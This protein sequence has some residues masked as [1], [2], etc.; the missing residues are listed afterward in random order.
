VHD[1]GIGMTPEQQSRLFKAFSQADSSTTRRFGGT[2]LGLS[3]SRSLALELGGD[4]TLESTPGQGSC[5]TLRTP[6]GSLDGVPLIS[7]QQAAGIVFS[8]ASPEDSNSRTPSKAPLEGVRIFFAEDGLDNQRLIMHH[9]RTAGA[10]VTVFNNGRL[11]LEALTE[12]GTV[13]GPLR[14]PRP[15]DVVVTD[16]QMP[17]MDGYT[18]ARTLRTKGWTRPIIALTA[19][20]MAS[21]AE[22]CLR[23][24]CD[25]YASKPVDRDELISMCQFKPGQTTPNKAA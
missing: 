24:G 21:D 16:M 1:T 22:K 12:D 25:G 23:C 15:C 8:N 17:E 9:L 5:F 3:I 19:H 4:I 2:G 10:E 6:T 13:G 20:A 18:L 14:Q 7:P 11:C